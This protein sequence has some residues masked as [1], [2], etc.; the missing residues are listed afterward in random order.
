MGENDQLKDYT[1]KLDKVMKY[2]DGDMNRAKQIIQGIIK[3]V[4]VIKGRLTFEQQSQSGLFLIFLHRYKL[5]I[6]DKF[7]LVKEGLGL[8]NNFSPATDSWKVIFRE[9]NESGLTDPDYVL[10]K[11]K[12]LS[13][14]FEKEFS[15]AI[16]SQ[17]IGKFENRDLTSVT[18]QMENI[19]NYALGKGN[20]FFL[21]L[22]FEEM[23]SLDYE[24]VVR[25][26]LKEKQDEEVKKKEAE[27][28]AEDEKNKKAELPDDDFSMQKN[29]FM[30]EGNNIV[31]GE[32]SLSPVKGKFISEVTTGE[33]ISCRI[34]DP[35][36]KGIAAIKQLNLMGE[37][38]R[39]K[40]KKGR[41]LYVYK[42]E[43]GFQ[44]LVQIAPMIIV[45]ILEEEEV[46]VEHFPAE[47]IKAGSNSRSNSKK[48]SKKGNVLPIVIA[49]AATAIV[50]LVL[51]I[52]FAF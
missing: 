44:L 16:I 7:A 10:E 18:V 35:S 14:Q 15:S 21:Q 24:E 36:K 9:I 41:V 48:A 19:C 3:D 42:S 20:D 25:A 28:A 30:A 51:I 1:D 6:I 11:S 46:K 26:A 2:T 32:L 27:K 33:V 43:R 12:S 52:L 45:E 47:G 4:I 22:D 13:T 5:Y 37:D 17:M 49:G 29:T 39:V 38:G 31:K 23:T 40:K 50:V 34:K 8:A